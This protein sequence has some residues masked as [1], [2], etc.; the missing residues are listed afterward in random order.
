MAILFEQKAPGI[1]RKLMAARGASLE[2]EGFLSLTEQ[3]H[4]TED[5]VLALARLIDGDHS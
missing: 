3:H 4:L 1:V 5:P 2:D